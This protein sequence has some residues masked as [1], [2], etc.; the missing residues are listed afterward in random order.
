[1]LIKSQKNIAKYHAIVCWIVEKRNL[2]LAVASI[3]CVLANILSAGKCETIDYDSNRETDVILETMFRLHD[4]T[5]SVGAAAHARQG[6][7]Y[8]VLKLDIKKF[9]YSLFFVTNK[10]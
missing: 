6:F 5:V 9:A 2:L 4:E 3:L 7:V 10:R 1:M 8:F